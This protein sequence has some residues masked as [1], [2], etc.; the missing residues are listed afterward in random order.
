[1]YKRQKITQSPCN[2]GNLAQRWLLDTRADTT[3]IESRKFQGEVLQA[4][5]IDRP[6]TLEAKGSGRAA[7]QWGLY[8]K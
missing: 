3:A 1:M 2:S 7:Q 6:V 4:H 5:G 8:L